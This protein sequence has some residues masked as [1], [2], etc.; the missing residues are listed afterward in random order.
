MAHHQT[1][2]HCHLVPPDGSRTVYERRKPAPVTGMTC[3]CQA[4]P[5]APGTFSGSLRGPGRSAT[6]SPIKAGS[7]FPRMPRCG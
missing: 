6:A 2:H 4:M 3:P 5:L 7:R 1:L